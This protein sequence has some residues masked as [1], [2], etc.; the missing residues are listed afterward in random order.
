MYCALG[1]LYFLVSG[2]LLTQKNVNPTYLRTC[3]YILTLPCLLTLDYH[4][5]TPIRVVLGGQGQ[6]VPKR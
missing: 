4:S 1:S 2:S 3:L 5:L 6:E